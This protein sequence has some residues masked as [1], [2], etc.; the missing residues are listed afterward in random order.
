MSAVLKPMHDPLFGQYLDTDGHLYME[1]PVMKEILAGLDDGGGFVLDFL[2]RFAGSEED[3]KMRARNRDNVLAVKGISA[4]GAFDPK[5]RVEALDLIGVR[6]QI[7]FGNT[8]KLEFRQNS[9]AARTVCRRFNDYAL[10]WQKKAGGDRVRVAC[11]INMGKVDW[12]IEEAK[13]VI[14]AGAK[15]VD[16]PCAQPPGGVSPAHEVWDP[17]W[18]L[19]EEAHVPATIHLGG[20]GLPYS[21]AAGDPMLPLQAWG[22]AAALRL[23]PADRSGGE[24]AVSP[25]YLLIAHMAAE[26]YL[27]VMV[28][29]GVFERFPKLSLGIFEFGTGWFGNAV[30]RM[31]GWAEFLAKVGKKYELKPSEFVSRNVRLGPFPTEDLATIVERHGM[32]DVFCFSTDYGHLEGSRDPVTKFRR[33][34]DRIGPGYDKAFF[35]DNPSLMFPGLK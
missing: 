3:L 11:Q 25:Y 35:V 10:D 14:K 21:K 23:K 4:L 30:E 18:A 7:V 26:V 15:V 8:V 1:P 24:E 28:M 34:T 22:D 27:Q 12:A 31:D 20:G 33:Y 2:E 16:L 6:S 19:L 29:G 9:D 17:F 13:R 5:E 32:K